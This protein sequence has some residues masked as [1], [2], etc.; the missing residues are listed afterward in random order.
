[1]A[2]IN[3]DI[4]ISD[5]DLNYIYTHVGAPFVKKE[6]IEIEPDDVKENIIK[7]CLWK[8]YTFF[9]IIN[10][11]TIGVNNTLTVMDYPSETTY[12]VAGYK[13]TKYTNQLQAGMAGMMPVTGANVFNTTAMING[14]VNRG[15]GTKYNFSTQLSDFATS[16]VTN[17]AFGNMFQVK[18]FEDMQDRR[19]IEFY[20]NMAGSIEVSFAEYCYDVNKVAFQRKYDFLD[21]A[22]SKFLLYISSLRDMINSD[23]PVEIDLSN[24]IDRANSIIENIEEKWN[25]SSNAVVLR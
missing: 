16:K 17:D 12:G 13:V 7:P 2:E 24:L 8:Y 14:N 3:S 23:F 18:H 4:V 1:M 20:S 25:N 10:K 5:T 21:Y 22:G 19:Q 6:D 9:P 11:V 15:Y